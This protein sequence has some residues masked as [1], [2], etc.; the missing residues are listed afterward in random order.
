MI[1]IGL[2]L[3][4]LAAAFNQGCTVYTETGIGYATQ[5]SQ[6]VGIVRMG[7]E[8]DLGWGL[9]I[10]EEYQHRSEILKGVPFNNETDHTSSDDFNVMLRYEW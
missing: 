1:R 4:L 3:M 9:S 10:K 8:Q 2:M 7:M 5:A 6:P